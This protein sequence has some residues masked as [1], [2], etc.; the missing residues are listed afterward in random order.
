MLWSLFQ[1]LWLARRVRA[2]TQ[3]FARSSIPARAINHVPTVEQSR[4]T[5]R[6][7]VDF[8]RFCVTIICHKVTRADPAAGAPLSLR[9]LR[10]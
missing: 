4:V 10:A 9:V 7:F 8:E 5:R 3:H 6:V 1:I 2:V